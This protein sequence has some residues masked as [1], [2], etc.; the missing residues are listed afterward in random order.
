MISPTHEKKG[1]PFRD[2]NRKPQDTAHHVSGLLDLQ[3]QLL[4]G[5]AAW[6]SSAAHDYLDEP[7]IAYGSMSSL[8]KVLGMGD[9]R[10]EFNHS[11]LF[12]LP[13]DSL[14]T[15]LW[16]SKAAMVTPCWRAV[17]SSHYLHSL[18]SHSTSA[19]A[20]RKFQNQLRS[21]MFFGQWPF[22]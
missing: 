10:V 3:G 11:Q 5:I 9:S 20:G 16:R 14:H 13:R 18:C 8:L 12:L 4:L 2:T 6:K 7:S 21:N 19:G 17:R 1:S 15:A 22:Y